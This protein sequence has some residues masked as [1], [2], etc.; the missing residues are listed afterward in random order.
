MSPKVQR[1]CIWCGPPL[2]A[3]FFV[4]LIAAHWFPPPSPGD[5]AEETARFYQQHTD[6]IRICALMSFLA[7]ALLAPPVAV[8]S[9]QIRRIEGPLPTL[10]NIQ[11][12][13]GGIIGGLLFIIPGL[14][15]GVAAFDP[16]RDPQITEALHSAGWLSLI[17]VVFPALLEYV[18]I[19][20]ATF[21]DRR[22]DPV[23]PRWFGYFN[24]WVAGLLLP[25]MLILFFHH[26]PFGWN[27]I[28]T[29]W[30]A[31]TVFTIWLVAML[32]VCLRAIAQQEAEEAAQQEAEEAGLPSR[33][34]H[35]V[36][37]PLAGT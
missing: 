8:I 7:G 28:F 32:V 1:I 9:S 16:G 6:G 37:V 23:F 35:G 24:L 18:S 34:E 22:A 4:G 12:G 19:A 17:V 3:A 14:F 15:W 11:F 31:A 13:L 33:R 25:S 29:F 30:L 20:I 36:P 21:T 27:G 5:S 10:A 26:G 2:M